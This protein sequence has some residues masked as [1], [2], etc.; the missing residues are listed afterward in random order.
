M[1]N[2]Q[3]FEAIRFMKITLPRLVLLAWLACIT[4][5]IAMA[6]LSFS[7]VLHPSFWYM[8]VPFC[9]MI[10]ATLAVLIGGGWRIIR[11]PKRM[12]A[13]FCLWLGLLPVLGMAAYFEYL[14]RFAE[15]RHHRINSFVVAGVSAS[16]LLGEPYLMMFYRC[17]YE[18]ERFVM[19]SDCPT[20][21]EKQMI[22]MDEH[23]RKMEK[24][25]GGEPK[26]K[27]YWVRGPVWGISGK[28]MCGWALGSRVNR[29]VN[30]DVESYIDVHEIAH[31]ALDEFV[32]SHENV[33]M[34]LH[35]GWA[36]VNSGAL[37]SSR[38]QVLSAIHTGTIK[39]LR[40]LTSPDW[41]FTSDGPIYPQGCMFVDYL[42]RHY[43][44]AKFLELCQKSRAETFS[45]DVESVLGKSLARLDEAYQAELIEAEKLPMSDKDYLLSMKLGEKVSPEKWR[46]FV[47]DYCAAV[48]RWRAAF[49]QS[50]IKL[51]M[52]T[53][54]REDVGG[55]TISG[56]Y[57]VQYDRDNQRQACTSTSTMNEVVHREVSVATLGKMF[58]LMRTD[59]DAWQLRRYKQYDG[60][61]KFP[62]W[63]DADN[64]WEHLRKPLL[65]LQ[66]K[67][68]ADIYDTKIVEIETKPERIR[69]H[70]ERYGKSDDA[71]HSRGFWELDAR[72]NFVYAEGQYETIDRQGLSTSQSR[73]RVEYETIEGVSVMKTA[74]HEYRKSN[75][76][77]TL[78]TVKLGS[79][80]FSPPPPDVF[81]IATYGKF[82]TSKF[83][84]NEEPAPQVTLGILAWITGGWG[85]LGLLVLL[86][87][88]LLK[89]R[90]RGLSPSKRHADSNVN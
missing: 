54:S 4:T 25:L 78:R 76:E 51:I 34:L 82:D 22:A 20:P 46:Q 68:S 19:F 67:L 18:G 70:F 9:V 10:V 73:G 33:P 77:Q 71:I 88:T 64:M 61:V 53:E 89:N 87:F 81:E 66:G 39:S 83:G 58:N 59:N 37:E 17:R 79:C 43:G 52:E 47:D 85:M 29:P 13:A 6:V 16:S 26:Y 3:S 48:D 50:S 36:Q 23:L 14:L 27:A 57:Q 55:K 75:E 24:S 7:R 2:V 49:R 41:Y 8:A 84:Q 38:E 74:H 63:L 90:N 56:V 5:F 45:D 80:K 35:E 32:P 72:N 1:G 44:H 15:V 28:Y 31:F 65:P 69:I 21:D 30:F 86:G 40:E 62:H 12:G 11:G 42:L 60:V